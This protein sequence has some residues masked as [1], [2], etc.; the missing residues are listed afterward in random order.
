MSLFECKTI[1]AEALAAYS[2]GPRSVQ[3]CEVLDFHPTDFAVSICAI[4]ENH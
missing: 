4:S 1:H 3:G 2:S